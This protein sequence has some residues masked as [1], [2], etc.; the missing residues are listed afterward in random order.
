M[1]ESAHCVRGSCKGRCRVRILALPLCV[2]ECVCCSVLQCVA[3][4]QE[5]LREVRILA[6]PLCVLE[7]VRCN[8]A[9]C[10]RS[11]GGSV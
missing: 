10:C 7:C 8:I 9:V 2:L 6:L 3:E 11:S 5:S 4:R 1:C